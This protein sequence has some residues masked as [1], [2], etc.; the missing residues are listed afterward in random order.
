MET[1]WI[2][3]AVAVLVFAVGLIVLAIFMNIMNMKIGFFE[4]GDYIGHIIKDH[5]FN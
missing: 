5:I 4:I 1:K 2:R 3:F